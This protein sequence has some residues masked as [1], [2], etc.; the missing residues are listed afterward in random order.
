MIVMVMMMQL[1]VS[2]IIDTIDNRVGDGKDNENV[3]FNPQ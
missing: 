2:V 1:I 3:S